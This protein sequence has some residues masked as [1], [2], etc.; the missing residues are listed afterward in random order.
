MKNT[1]SLQS[2]WVLLG[3]LVLVLLLAW[4]LMTLLQQVHLQVKLSTQLEEEL[5]TKFVSN[6]FNSVIR[7]AETNIENGADETSQ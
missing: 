2:G 1:N 5:Q 7:Q 3:S 4:P 6:P